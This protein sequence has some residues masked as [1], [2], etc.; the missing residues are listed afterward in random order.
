MPDDEQK[1]DANQEATW[2]V[3]A[4]RKLNGPLVATIVG[5]LV[6]AV[7]AAII[8]GGSDDSPGAPQGSSTIATSASVQSSPPKSATEEAARRPIWAAPP[9][10]FA[11]ASGVTDFV[12]D[13]NGPYV[14][15]TAAIVGADVRAFTPKELYDDAADIAGLP[16]IVVGRVVSDVA[17][18]S[19][20]RVTHAVRLVGADPAYDVYVGAE[21]AGYSSGDVVYA[22]GRVA[23]QGESRD[24]AGHGRQ[25]TYFLATV[26][27][28]GGGID[29]VLDFEHG[30]DA[31]L[32]RARAARPASK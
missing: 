22:R 29:S 2:Y 1:Q 30:S 3:Q 7:L 9:V 5:G 14:A 4:W 19:A 26:N 24:A 13:G 18:R 11:D 28:N 6:V 31:I 8:F 15:E 21:V 20:F 17:Q 10:T 25:T 16:V 23:A 12:G 32:S 27:G